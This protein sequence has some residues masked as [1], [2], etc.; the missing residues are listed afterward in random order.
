MTQTE[1][2]APDIT[3]PA[4]PR[5]STGPNPV[6]WWAA[7]G[8]AV[9]LFQLYVY[10]AWI[11]S[12][13]TARV[14]NGPTPV[15]GWHKIFAYTFWPVSVTLMAGAIY[16][17]VVRPWRRDHRLN[18]DSLMALALLTLWFNDP[19][20]NYRGSWVTFTTVIPNFGSWGNHIPGWSAERFALPMVVTA[21][22]YIYWAL[23]VM[24][25][26]CWVMRR[27][28]T[29]WTGLGTVRLLLICLAVN[30]TFDLATELVWLR[31]GYWTYAGATR[32]GTIFYGHY[33]QL[34]FYFPL[35]AAAILTAWTWLR[36]SRDDRGLTFAERG[37]DRIGVQSQRTRTFLR[38]LAIAGCMNLLQFATYGAP[39]G[40]LSRFAQPWPDDIRS[41]S[42]LTQDLCRPTFHLCPSLLPPKATRGP[43]P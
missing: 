11:A 4:A 1:I 37:I 36:Y 40:F 43:Q 9:L 31:L 14:P 25:V 28:K 6:T 34:P 24:C 38:F 22:V 17:F 7:L 8:A 42:Y 20:S 30:F 41:R 16:W 21:T 32:F 35:S 29:R 39:M 2:G 12:G 3:R 15:P 13:D 23:P 27:A 33:Y 10:T 19:W 18:G 5:R 26:S